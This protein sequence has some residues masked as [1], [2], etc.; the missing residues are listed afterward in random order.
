MSKCRSTIHSTMHWMRIATRSTAFGRTCLFGLVI[1]GLIQCG[2]AAETDERDFFENKI[3]P[4]LVKHCYQCHSADSENI[5]G[6]L[7]LD[8]R[9]SVREGGQS[10]PAIVAGEPDESLLIQAIRYDHVEMPPDNPLPEAVVNDFVTW[11]RRG[12]NDPR[13]TDEKGTA[14]KLDAAS[15]WSFLPRIAAAVPEVNDHAWPLD[16][17]DRFVL[18][19]IE[20]AA[21]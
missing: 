11:V 1:G 14:S 6:G 12:A 5:G 3:R 2:H 4:A 13:V 18:S 16:P 19:R 7:L 21:A 17:L 9:D 8:S 20:S 10:G 15:L